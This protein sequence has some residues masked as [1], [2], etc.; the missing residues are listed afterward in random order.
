VTA[1]LVD[2]PQ[3]FQRTRQPAVQQPCTNDQPAARC[4]GSLLAPR[5][6]RD[7]EACLWRLTRV[8]D[9]C[10]FAALR[11]WARRSVSAEAHDISRLSSSDHWS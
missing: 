7:S 9:C 3:G 1:V 2:N 11:Y 10:W 4:A 6:R 8:R 5:P